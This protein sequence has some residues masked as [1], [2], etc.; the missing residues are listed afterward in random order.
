VVVPAAAVAGP[1]SPAVRYGNLLFTSGQLGLDP[2]S[3]QLAG[4]DIAAESR[5]ALVNLQ[6]V[7]RDGGAELDQVLKVTLYLV[8]AADFATVNAVYVEFFRP[9]YPARTCVVVAA[10]PKG[11]RIEIEAIA[12]GD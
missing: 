3:G 8:D 11:A 9:P 6:A 2:A 12:R 10:L 5:Q 1:Y 4:P 7:L